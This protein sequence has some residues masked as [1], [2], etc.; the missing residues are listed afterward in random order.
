MP[1]EDYKDLNSIAVLGG[2]FDPVHCGHLVA[3]NEVMQE[4]STEGVIS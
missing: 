1:H 2:T 4:F 3:A